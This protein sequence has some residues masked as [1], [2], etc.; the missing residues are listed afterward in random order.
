MKW[1][2][3]LQIVDAHCGGEI[4]KVVT[5]QVLEIPGATM[6]ARM[7]YIN[8]TD[9]SLRRL[10]T[11]EPRGSAPMSVN[12]LMPPLRPDADAGLIVLQA[13]RAH[14]MSGSNAICVTTVLLETGILPMQEGQ[15]IVRLDTPAG[16]VTA[17]A[18]CLD[19]RCEKVALDMTPAFVQDLDVAIDTERFGRVSAD[20]AFGGVFYALVDVEQLGFRID[21]DNAT[22]LVDAGTYLKTQ[23]EQHVAVRHPENPDLNNLA[24]V[25]FRQREEDEAIR[26]C[27]AMKQGRLDRSPCGTGSSAQSAVMDAKGE[28]KSGDVLVTRSIIGSEFRV[29]HK[30]AKTLSS[31]D[32]AVLPNITGSAWIYGVS[33]IGLDPTDPF[34]KGFILGDTWGPYAHEL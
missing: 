29:E 20:I 33:Q 4:G 28:V 34:P 9:D 19:G 23:F 26:T 11:T 5:S 7:N 18:T 12:L 22:Q 14:P 32:P 16:L 8:N 3:T 17:N 6:L 15:K 30:G 10:L 2:K 27:T 13:D 21:P 24:Y 25:M 31:G 1:K